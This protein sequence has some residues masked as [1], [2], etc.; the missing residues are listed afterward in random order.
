VHT[1]VLTRLLGYEGADPENPG[2]D[3]NYAVGG[4]RAIGP[5]TAADFVRDDTVFRDD[6]DLSLLDT[7]IDVGAQVDRFLADAETYGWDLSNFTAHMLIGINDLSNWEPESTF[8]WRWD[9]EIRDLIDD[10]VAAIEVNLRKLLDAGIGAIWVANN[11]DETFFPVYNELSDLVRL[12]GNGV[13][14]DLNDKV[15]DMVAALGDDRL[16]ILNIEEMTDQ[17]EEDPLNFGRIDLENPILLGKGGDIEPTLNPDLPA[18]FEFATDAN[19]YGFLDIVHPTEG[20]HRILRIYEAEVMQSNFILGNVGSNSLDGTD[21]DDLVLAGAGQDEV[22]LRGGDDV[23]IGGRGSDRISG[24][25]GSD[26]I[27]GGA[28]NDRI[29]GDGGND[30]LTGGYG[31]DTVEGGGGQDLIVD[32]AGS[33]ILRGGANDDFFFWFDGA[34]GPDTI[35]G[36]RGKDT[37]IFYL[38]DTGTY[39]AAVAEKSGGRTVVFSSLD[40]TVIGIGTIE[41]VDLS[42]EPLELPD[43]L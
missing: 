26:L 18:E 4:A 9:N 36:G 40:V 5:L 1:Q 24:G 22:E 3:Y 19:D 42:V 34:Q 13:V 7:R 43:T 21:N 17:I 11:P 35:D 15:E 6:A 10:I 41:F 38:S 2:A 14:D 16:H 31:D 20:T 12:V 29:W 30:L 28:G 25:S 8:P 33:D 39:D 32:T 37:L 27:S 23:A